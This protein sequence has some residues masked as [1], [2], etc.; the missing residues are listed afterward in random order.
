MFR[1][2]STLFLLIC[3]TIPNISQASFGGGGWP[4]EEN[5]A[6]PVNVQDQTSPTII[7]PLIRKIASTTLSA[8]GVLGEYNIEVVSSAGFVVGQYIRLLDSTNNRFYSG[9][10][11]AIVVNT[12]T[13]DSQL[14][15]A[16]AS[17]SQAT[18]GSDNMAVD[19]SVTPVIFELRIDDPTLDITVDITRLMFS[20][21]TNTA[22]DLNKFGDLPPLTRG[23]AFRRVNGTTNNIFNVKT[24]GELKGICYDYDP[25]VASN[26]AQAVDG[27]HAR[28]T[29]AGQS[30]M[31][32]A[33]KIGPNGNLQVLVQDDQTGLVF[34][35]II[36]EGHVATE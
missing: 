33:L 11:L 14:D 28:L 20:C 2:L 21:E 10:V 19:G 24:N 5:G 15:F 36:V 13:L 18:V 35:G 1:F 34:L 22:V 16:F 8:E 31:G 25:T 3:L 30:K 9:K 17:G 12:I 26:P 29:T 4:S 27:F 23:L 32:V 7:I 6:V